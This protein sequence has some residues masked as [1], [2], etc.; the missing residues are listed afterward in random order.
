MLSRQRPDW[1]NGD[2][3]KNDLTFFHRIAVK[4]YEV[5][6]LVF[7]RGGWYDVEKPKEV[8]P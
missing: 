1:R 3:R 4:L 7:L 8:T 5:F 2:R 6:F